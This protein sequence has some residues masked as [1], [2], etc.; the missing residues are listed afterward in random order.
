MVRRSNRSNKGQHSSSALQPEYTPIPGETV[1]CLVC[2]TTDAEYDESED[3]REMIECENCKTWQHIECM[4][5]TNFTGK[6]PD[7]YLCDV[8]DPESWFGLK[9]KLSYRMYLERHGGLES[10]KQEEEYGDGVV[11]DEDDFVIEADEFRERKKQKVGAVSSKVSRTAGSSNKSRSS[12]TT[13]KKESVSDGNGK[14]KELKVDAKLE[15]MRNSI[16]KSFENKLKTL[17]PLE[18]SQLAPEW[19]RILEEGV[20]QNAGDYK[21]HA[22]MLLINLSAS[23]LVERVLDGEFSIEELPKLSSDDMRTREQREKDEEAK[24]KALGQ[25]V[26]KQEEDGLVKTRLTHRG[27]EIIGEEEFRFD[28]EDRRAS[29]VDK[30]RDE[31][32]DNDLYG[33]YE[34]DY[35]DEEGEGG[36]DDDGSDL[37]DDEADFDDILKDHRKDEVKTASTEVEEHEYEPDLEN[38]ET[39][40]VEVPKD[41]TIDGKS[42]IINTLER[43][44]ACLVKFVTST[45]TGHKRNRQIY[46]DMGESIFTKGRINTSSVD[47]Y[48][49]KVVISKDIYLYQVTGDIS[50]IWSGYY[51]ISRYGVLNAPQD[52][53]KDCY[54]MCLSKEKIIDGEEGLT[55]FSKFDKGDILAHLDNEQEDDKLVYIVYVVRK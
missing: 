41:D 32:E 20:S 46:N 27:V 4:Y 19:A 43:D 13:Q 30:L 1:R 54:L 17:L 44:F 48:L 47:S 52:Y 15:S 25:V 6:I 28:V 51:S 45:S 55:L 14:K 39:K 38:K 36:A 11:D 22:R 5:G 49:D 33:E 37:L 42:I 31:R 23:K 53:V 16:R 9:K 12:P 10:G 50:T 29:E 3:E 35:N 34:G 24:R 26:L 21:D 7:K 8:C 18:K 2:G 40:R